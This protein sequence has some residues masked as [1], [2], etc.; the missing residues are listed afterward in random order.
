MEW[1]DSVAPLALGL[2]IRLGIPVLVT[3]LLVR[4]LRRL[5][6]RW[7]AEAEARRSQAAETTQARNIGCWEIKGCTAEQLATCQA[8]AHPKTPCWQW[9]REDGGHLQERCL[10]CEVF[11]E[12]PVPV[13]VTTT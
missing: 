12:S 8:H 2:V 9:F 7:Q 10:G 5:D 1:L 3:F 11:R 4:W 13:P 6:E